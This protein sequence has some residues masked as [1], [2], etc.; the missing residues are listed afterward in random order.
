MDDN[1][2]DNNNDNHND[3]IHLPQIIVRV[4][5]ILSQ[6]K[7]KKTAFFLWFL[8]LIHQK[9]H[10][11]SLK[12]LKHLYS[13]YNYTIQVFF[14]H[15]NLFFARS[16]QEQLDVLNA[17]KIIENR[18]ELNELDDLNTQNHSTRRPAMLTDILSKSEKNPA[19]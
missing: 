8:A 17:L 19:K 6:K 3:D 7:K 10:Q 9:A 4:N 15:C 13:N 11:I 12:G 5:G 1:D 2:N 16:N 18:T 14:S